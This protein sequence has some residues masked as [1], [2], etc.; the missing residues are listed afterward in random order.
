MQIKEDIERYADIIS[1]SHHTSAKHPRMS[2]ENRAAQFSPFA[3]LTGYEKE[4][5][6]TARLTDDKA[7]PDEDRINDINMKIQMIKDKIHENPEI[8]AEYFIPDKLKSGG[9]YQTLKGRV[10][11]I[12]EYERSIVLTDGKRIMI[13]NIYNLELSGDV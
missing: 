2:R 12:D 4:I 5:K 6:E 13:E 11:I 7:E 1:L 3:A 8:T 10:R 9:E